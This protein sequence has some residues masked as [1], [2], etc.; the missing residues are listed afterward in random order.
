MELKV[1]ND[2]DA[3]AR[4]SAAAIAADARSAIAGRGLLTFDVSGAHTPWIILR[5][6]ADEDVP[7]AGV[8]L[9]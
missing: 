8:H 5:V 4:R 9:Y 2:P 3:A 7:W 6:L 1:V